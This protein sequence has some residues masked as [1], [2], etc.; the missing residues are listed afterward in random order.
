VSSGVCCLSRATIEERIDE[1]LC[2]KRALFTDVIDGVE[3][4][5]LRRL[6]LDAL[7]GA[8]KG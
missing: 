7:L 6:N 8:I 2:D 4:A 5:A 3:T 1:I